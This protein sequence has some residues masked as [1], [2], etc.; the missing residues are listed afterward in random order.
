MVMMLTDMELCTVHAEVEG[1]VVGP[2]GSV[3]GQSSTSSSCGCARG[4]L[5][6]VGAVP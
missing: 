4:G 5:L 3:P 6:R 1:A 2:Q